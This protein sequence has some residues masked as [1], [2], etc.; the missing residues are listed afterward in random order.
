MLCPTEYCTAVAV[1]SK[2]ALKNFW[3]EGK[4]DAETNDFCRIVE[5]QACEKQGIDK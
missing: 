2:Y 5:A 1:L 3:L 4:F